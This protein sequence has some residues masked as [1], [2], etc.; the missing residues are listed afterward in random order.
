MDADGRAVVAGVHFHGGERRVALVAEGLA[1]IGADLHGPAGI[2]HHGQGQ[3]RDGE[4][5]A[6]AAVE[7]AERRAIE[8]FAAGGFGVGIVGIGVF[9]ERVAAAVQGVA[10]EA[11]DYGR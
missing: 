7:E 3:K 9:V 2:K 8:F 5:D 6:L 1:R 10:S 4:V 11:R